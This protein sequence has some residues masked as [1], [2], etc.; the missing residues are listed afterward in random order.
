MLH[1]NIDVFSSK[2]E[3][4]MVTVKNEKNKQSMIMGNCKNKRF[5]RGDYLS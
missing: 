3:D 2:I 5:S 1:A 4:V